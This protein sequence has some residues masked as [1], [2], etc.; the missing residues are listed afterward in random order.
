MYINNPPNVYHF[1]N[2]FL[3]FLYSSSLDSPHFG[4]KDVV[5]GN[6]GAQAHSTVTTSKANDIAVNAT[7][8]PHESVA[9]AS[10]MQQP[11][12]PPDKHQI[13]KD[14]FWDS[15]FEAE[16]D[17]PDWRPNMNQDELAR[18]KPKERKRQDVIN[19]KI[20]NIFI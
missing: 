17:P 19:G 4:S 16:R 9:H 8:T 2:S 20:R 15:D 18:L 1:T 12:Y 11:P 14:A 3:L 6:S 7:G 10:S 5:T 13:N